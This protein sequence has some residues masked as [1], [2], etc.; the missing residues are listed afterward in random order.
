MSKT[1][2]DVAQNLKD[3]IKGHILTV[4]K[5]YDWQVAKWKPFFNVV[6]DAQAAAFDTFK[7]TLENALK[8][9]Q[10]GA[11]L[12]LMALSMAGGA[13]IGWLGT[14]VKGHLTSRFAKSPVFQDA[15]V[16][17]GGYEIVKVS[18]GTLEET[19]AKAAYFGDKLEK[20]LGTG[21]DKLVAKVTPKTELKD[22]SRPATAD[23]KSKLTQ[24]I[25]KADYASFKTMITAV[26]DEEIRITTGQF[27]LWY[28]ATHNDRDFGTK[29]LAAVKAKFNLP[30]LSPDS[31]ETFGVNDIDDYIDKL[32][33]KFAKDWFYYGND[34]DE[35][36]I[37]SLPDRIEKE[38]W[39]LWIIDQEFKV[40]SLPDPL[41]KSRE[42]RG[43]DRIPLNHRII[44]HLMVDLS[45]A[46][47]QDMID[48]EYKLQRGFSERSG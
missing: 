42:V 7:T 46:V 23:L 4:Q 26:L 27:G 11:E 16:P 40:R 6:V 36:G 8:D 15:F 3:H 48:L 44:K 25:Q 17:G 35:K 33:N 12:L 5:E 9:S 38:L 14:V 45:G 29:L 37:K 24:T 39:A 47:G 13:A 32:R 2:T 10:R 30:H 20:G 18:A 19:A 34:P 1:E 22:V 21:L 43:K 31:L 28:S 41:I